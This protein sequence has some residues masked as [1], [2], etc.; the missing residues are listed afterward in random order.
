M[1]DITDSE[2]YAFQEDVVKKK[3]REVVESV[4]G[5]CEYDE[6]LVPVWVDSI[7]ALCVEELHAAKKPY[8][9]IVTTTILQRTGSA[10]HSSRSAYW[11]GVSDGAVTVLWPK[12]NATEQQSKTIIAMVTVFAL[13]F[14]VN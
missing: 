5:S 7:C 2:K 10:I 12:R 11:D 9:Y 14:Y 8:K 1:D 6:E 13:A 3:V 4:L